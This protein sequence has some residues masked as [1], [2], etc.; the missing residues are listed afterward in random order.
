MSYIKKAIS[1]GGVYEKTTLPDGLRVVTEKIPAS[2]SVSIG[3][4]IDVGSRN[5]NGDEVGL[6]HFIEHMVFKGTKRRSSRQIADSL[7]SLGG[8]LN[9]FTSREQT[10]YTA[11]VL[12]EFTDDAIDVLADITCH[13]RMTPVN[14]AREGLVICEE[15]KE[16][17]D[18]PGDH[19]H[20]L[21]SQTFWGDH[22]LGQPIMGTQENIKGM[23]RARMKAYMNR[24]YRAGSV[25]IAAS[26]SISHRKLVKLVRDKFTFAKGTAGTPQKAERTVKKNVLVSKTDGNQVHHC[27]GFPAFSYSDRRRM[28]AIVLNTYLGSGMSS[29]FFQK[30]RENKGLAYSIFS[31]LDF[32]RDAGMF[33]TY[34][35]TDKNKVEQAHDIVL[36]EC[37]KVKRNRIK[38][39]LLSKVKAQ[40][41]GNITLAME[42]T[43]NKMHR[44]G[45]MELIMGRFQPLK[46][47]LREFDNVTSSQIL[48]VANDIM[49]E[50]QLAVTVLGP[51]DSKFKSKS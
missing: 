30:V 46:S 32:F 11:R 25:V 48:E 40:I 31:Y 22:P 39:E 17:L 45:R 24:H 19:V 15:I 43:S 36:A 42:S 16:S 37:R 27:L 6:S 26:G 44:L 21:F 3:V 5:E 12:D 2:R 4:W 28:A 1:G 49:D 9:A 33:G 8:S 7:E 51:V 13:A 23:T 38:S 18:N 41:K 47:T 29:V 34:L 35:S 20:D 50:S 14:L 10:C